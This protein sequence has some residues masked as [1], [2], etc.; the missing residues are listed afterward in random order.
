MNSFCFPN[1]KFYGAVCGD[2]S[3]ELLS[4]ATEVRA[5]PR[6][7]T[8]TP[9]NKGAEQRST[10]NFAHYARNSQQQERTIQVL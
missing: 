8:G 5:P 3:W 4:R 7:T 1:K 9:V 2:V 10:A 6:R